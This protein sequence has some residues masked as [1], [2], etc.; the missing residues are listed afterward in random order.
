MYLSGISTYLPKCSGKT[1][2]ELRFLIVIIQSECKT[3]CLYLVHTK[4]PLKFFLF[5]P[6]INVK[7]KNQ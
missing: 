1:I 6:M 4:K 2:P 7:K 3:E 5:I